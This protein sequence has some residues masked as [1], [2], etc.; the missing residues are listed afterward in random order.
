MIVATA[1][2]GSGAQVCLSTVAKAYLIFQR[3]L[4]KQLCEHAQSLVGQF[5]INE[6]LL[7][8]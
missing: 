5:L 2:I 1:V 4:P 3:A 7:P 6:R 8:G